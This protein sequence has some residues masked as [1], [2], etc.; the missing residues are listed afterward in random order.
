MS[1]VMQL[2]EESGEFTGYAIDRERRVR[3]KR[4]CSR[5]AM[6]TLKSGLHA[7]PQ[8]MDPRSWMRIENQ[9]SMG[10]CQG[11]AQSSVGELCFHVATG[12]VTQFSPLFAYYATQ[13]VDGL[14]G[15]DSGST[16]GGGVECAM[17]VGFCPLEL[18]PYPDPPR[19][20]WWISEEARQAAAAFRIR[21]RVWIESYDEAFTFLATGQGGIEIGMGW[22]NGLSNCAGII[23]RYSSGGG[24]HAVCFLGYSARRDS[25]GRAYLW[26]AN[27]WSVDW[28]ASGWAEV[29]P[30]AVEQM[31]AS[32]R[33]TA[34]GMSDLTTPTVRRVDWQKASVYA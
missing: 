32:S 22:G 21:Q 11:H 24:G 26:L 2:E 33:T 27:S 25:E 3:V 7:A 18:M 13:E 28:G 20:R 1:L 9:K 31:L 14:V 4:L 23:E 30:R 16:I 29:A 5:F 10:S 8:E 19:Y 6:E 17:K 15:R 12:K 34:V